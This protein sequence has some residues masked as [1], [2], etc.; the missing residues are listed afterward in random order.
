MPNTKLRS[1]P[2]FHGC[3]SANL[4]FVRIN[5]RRLS[6]SISIVAKH[7]IR[8]M[9]AHI[10]GYVRRSVDRLE[11]YWAAPRFLVEDGLNKWLLDDP[12][13]CVAFNSAH[14]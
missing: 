13:L 9:G 3:G 10:F 6:G 4:G 5:W 12:A 8:S 2:Q 7:F 11:K 1:T 14:S